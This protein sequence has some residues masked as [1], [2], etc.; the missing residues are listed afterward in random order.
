MA[1]PLATDEQRRTQGWL[2]P[3][4]AATITPG[5]RYRLVGPDGVWVVT[6]LSTA[7]DTAEVLV[8][9][10]MVNDRHDDPQPHVFTTAEAAITFA[11][12]FATERAG[13]N[14]DAFA[15]RKPN[16]DELYYAVYSVE[17]DC[18]WVVERE[19]NSG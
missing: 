18:V 8:Y 2:D 3:E 5:G 12:N 1:E 7:G 9:V 10:V 17:N 11:R 19:L 13:H 14:P 4:A 15:E 6:G 16:G